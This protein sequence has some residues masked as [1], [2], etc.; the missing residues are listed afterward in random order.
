[1]HSVFIES[2]SDP[3]D[4]AQQESLGLVSNVLLEE[5]RISLKQLPLLDSAI[6]VVSTRFNDT[7][8]ARSGDSA[9]ELYDHER[10]LDFGAGAKVV[11]DPNRELF[12][13]VMHAEFFHDD[14]EGRAQRDRERHGLDTLRIVIHEGWHVVLCQRGEDPTTQAT[15]LRPQPQLPRHVSY[16]I[17]AL[18]LDEFR[19]ELTLCKIGWVQ[20]RQKKPYFFFEARARL[21]AATAFKRSDSLSRQRESALF[22]CHTYASRLASLAAEAATTAVPRH[23]RSRNT[24]G[25][26]ETGL[27]YWAT[28][29]DILRDVPTAAE[30]YP[31]PERDA[32][33]LAMV[34]QV[35]DWLQ[36]IAGWSPG[37][38]E[39][40][41]G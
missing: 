39:T 31:Q 33:Y 9:L 11:F 37:L 35:D 18:I 34:S 3:N 17:A 1:V 10:P 16:D 36:M 12:T 7:V 13:I 23:I 4:L 24:G 20:R 40:L 8:R 25:R 6:L 15:R 29:L 26:R 5:A 38:D 32:V 19:V 27:T 41:N 30:E 22:L 21:R 14:P 2:D 28:I